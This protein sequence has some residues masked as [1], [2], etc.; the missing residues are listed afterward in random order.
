MAYFYRAD[1]SVNLARLTVSTA[2]FVGVYTNAFLCTVKQ[3]KDPGMDPAM[4]AYS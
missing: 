2:L 4:Q 1:G 3:V